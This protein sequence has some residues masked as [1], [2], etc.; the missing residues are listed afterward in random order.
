MTI[1]TNQDS[2]PLESSLNP[3]RGYAMSIVNILKMELT[4]N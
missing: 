3:I 2:F 1:K 4:R